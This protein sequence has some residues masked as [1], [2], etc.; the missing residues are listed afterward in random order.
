[1]NLTADSCV[2]I[3]NID[4]NI[5]IAT[6]TVPALVRCIIAAVKIGKGVPTILAA[7]NTAV[8]GT[9]LNPVLTHSQY[10]SARETAI[11]VLVTKK[12]RLMKKPRL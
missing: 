6:V 12:Q 10:V 5:E 4:F 7:K 11:S 9:V 1:M 3:S 2:A 8:I